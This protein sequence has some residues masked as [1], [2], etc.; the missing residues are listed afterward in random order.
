MHARIA[1]HCTKSRFKGPNQSVRRGRGF[2][3][4]GRSQV[5]GPR[6]GGSLFLETSFDIVQNREFD[7]HPRQSLKGDEA[8]FEAQELG[9]E[10][11]ELTESS[12]TG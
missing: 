2:K 5:A 1:L 8:I 12:L 6:L 7:F 10:G 3:F 11:E 9:R 4:P